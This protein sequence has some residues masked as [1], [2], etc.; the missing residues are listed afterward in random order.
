MKNRFDRRSFLKKAGCTALGASTLAW[1]WPAVGELHEEEFSFR[2]TWP[3][4]LQRPWPGPAYWPN[5]LQDWRV[6]A[7]R[8]ECISSGGDRNVALLTREV[9]GRSGN[10]KLSV[11]LGSLDGSAQER[12]FVGFR[13][14]I[15]YPMQD[16][17][18]TAIYGRGMNVGIHA[19]G[20]LFIG[21]LEASAPKIDIK[22]EIRLQFYAHPSAKG[23]KVLLRAVSVNG[24]R[25]VEIDREIPA[26]WLIGGLALACSSAELEPTPVEFPMIKDFSF[27]PP[28]QHAGGTMKFW[29][30]DW[31]ISGSKIDV[32]DERAYGPILFTLYTV[33]RGSLKLSAQ[34]PPL[35]NVSDIATLQIKTGS[36]WKSI[37]IAKLDPDAWNATF[38][39]PS[40]KSEQDCT[41]R[42][43][44]RMP[45]ENGKSTEYAYSGTIRRDPR[46]RQNIVVGLLTCLWDFGFPHDDFTTHLKH[47]QPDILLWTGDQVY[48]P[49]GGFGALEDR[50]PDLIEAAMLDFQRK[51]FIFGWAVRDLTR[52]IPSVCMTDDHDMYHG[53]IWGCG[54]R[55][56]NPALRN[57]AAAQGTVSYSKKEYAIQDSGGY[58]MAPQW[59]NMVQRLQTSH[60]PD[61]YDPTPVLQGINVYYCEL[62]WGGISFAILEDRKWKSAPKGL[63]PGADIVNGFALSRGWD[64]AAQSDDQDAELLG[65]RQLDFLEAWAADWS[66]GAW[67]KFAVSQTIF[68]CIHTEPQGVYT[69]DKD[70]EETIPPEGTYLEGDHLVAD[71]DSNAWPQH[72][73]NAA[74]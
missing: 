44:Y 19:D 26:E 12:G 46:D 33:S 63:L 54:G 72:E 13:V 62:L 16:Y 53:N 6:H 1:D 24:G 60:L 22:H 70:P 28:N 20:R 11:R 50:T 29:F 59:V 40:W 34:F 8:L 47:H 18:A 58:K 35:G 32:H 21:T 38:R 5:P 68:A 42:V 10:L 41:Y 2:S 52:D 17:R 27:Y 67:M 31:T 15:K 73:R 69:D 55:P 48:E 71:Y 51:W 45:D 49:V 74:I 3:H 43:I 57:G 61:A 65:Q 37:A 14:G 39:V 66:G 9:S 56:T 4:G 30:R 23:Y 25:S 64:S 36:Q 7:G